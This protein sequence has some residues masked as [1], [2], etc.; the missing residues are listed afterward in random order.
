MVLSYQYLIEFDYLGKNVAHV[1]SIRGGELTHGW[2]SFMNIGENGGAEKQN[3]HLGTNY[4]TL[5]IEIEFDENIKP[6][7]NWFKE[8]ETKGINQETR[9]NLSL[10]FM[11][12]TEKLLTWNIQKAYPIK[13]TI[14]NLQMEGTSS[15]ATI[16][17]E[18][19]YSYIDVK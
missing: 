6:W 9:R 17:M 14:N 3:I 16:G 7:L 11:N 5:N 19:K 15:G 18:L 13:W 8:V 12:G 10:Y 1:R 4:T 2:A